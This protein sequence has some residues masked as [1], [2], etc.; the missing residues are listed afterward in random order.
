MGTAYKLSNESKYCQK[1]NNNI[2]TFSEEVMRYCKEKGVNNA[3][4][5]TNVTYLSRNIYIKLYSD[6]RYI[7]DENT[8]YTICF[9]LKLNFAEATDLLHK[10]N[11]SMTP[12]DKYDTYRELLVEMLVTGKQFIPHCNN[13][14]RHFGY[15]EL[16]SSRNVN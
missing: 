4:Q 10:A 16:G 11:Y 6:R 3:N 13:T 14:L 2:T 1:Q 7:P 9:G 8:A 12:I 5:F 15:R